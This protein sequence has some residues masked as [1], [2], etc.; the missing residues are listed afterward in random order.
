MPTVTIE[1]QAPAELAAV[2]LE[3]RGGAVFPSPD[4]WRDQVLYFLLPDRFSD[5]GETGRPL[6]DRSQPAAHRAASRSE[7]M[8]AGKVFQGGTIKGIRSKLDYVRGL[9]ATALWI[10]PVWKQ[11]PD[12]QTYHGYGIQDFLE[13]DPRFGTRQDLRD[14]VDAAH[15]KGMYVVLDIIYNHTGNNWF[16]RDGN[17]GL[18]EKRP[19]SFQPYDKG[20]RWRSAT[21]QPIDAIQ[22]RGDGVWPREFQDPEFYT[23]S[24][25]IVDWDPAPWENPLDPR[26]QFR[27]GDFFDLKDLRVQEAAPLSPDARAQAV[28][29]AL[30]RVYQYWIALTDC[31]GFRVDTVKHVSFEASRNFCGAIHEYAE[32]IGKQNFLLLGEVAGGAGMARD[33]LDIFGRNLDAA[34]D[35]GVPMDILTRTAKGLGDPRLFFSQFGG[36]DALGS[37]REIG[38]YHVSMID[39]HDLIEREPKA[40]FSAGNGAP[41]RYAQA[42]HAVGM[43][44]TTLGI[45]CIYYGTEQAFAGS[46]NDHDLTVESRGDDGKI[47]YRDRYVREAMFGATFGAFGTSGCH[48]FDPAHPTYLRIA[49]IARVVTRR[50]RI[51][52]ALR[53]GRQYP[54]DV[55]ILSGY[56]PPR[57]GELI[58]WS[59]VLFDREVVV[60]LDTNGDAGR[61]GLVTVDRRIHPPGSQLDVLYRGD[62]SDAQL[63]NPPTGET[64]SVVDDDGRS[65]VRIDLP[66]AG[67][68]IL[69]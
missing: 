43:Q 11:R 62:W 2:N 24:G 41:A 31:D 10:G 40:R 64:L 44:L 22:D 7:W 60:A 38:R 37:H 51:G 33:Y 18:F 29:D 4:D 67:M 20:I 50:D 45:P 56:A 16:Y 1:A 26:T 65:A 9:G 59:R 21:G 8:R 48:F 69:A 36:Q 58:A 6:F 54:R 47:P 14:L 39:D 35:L 23:R 34:I 5:G 52:M 28:L 15:D 61:G 13:V 49:A 63:S 57:S 30:V 32:A 46:E 55:K 42:A 3:P 19:Y 27:R 12:L 17:G 66:A 25:S 68:I 53:R